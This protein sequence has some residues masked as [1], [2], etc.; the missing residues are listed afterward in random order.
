MTDLLNIF[1]PS[2]SNIFFM[3][4]V[5][6]IGGFALGFLFKSA[7]IAKYKKRVTN[8]EDE[9]LSSHSHILE[10]EQQ[11]ADLKEEKARLSNITPAAKVE[12]KVS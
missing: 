2:A 12:L 5:T 11:V 1:T 8:L 3:S 6:G 10:L 4:A 7:V 9:M